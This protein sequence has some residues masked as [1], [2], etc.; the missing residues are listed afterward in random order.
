VDE[1]E[2]LEEDDHDGCDLTNAINQKVLPFELQAAADSKRAPEF[3]Y[4]S[5]QLQQDLNALGQLTHPPTV[6]IRPIKTMVGY[7]VGD[8]SGAGHGSSFLY[9]GDDYLDLVH[10]TWSDKASLRSSNFRELANLVRRVEQLLEHKKYWAGR[11]CLFLRTILLL[12]R[13]FTRAPQ[14]HP[15]CTV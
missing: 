9:T 15:T 12:S 8:A 1:H 14:R 10:G 11:N 7:L 2:G 13:F 5:P 6:L 3:V 4:A